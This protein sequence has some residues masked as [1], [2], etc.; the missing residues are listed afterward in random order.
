MRFQY[1]NFRVKT[2]EERSTGHVWT[3]GAKWLGI[4][5]A[6]TIFTVT[7]FFIMPLAV[8]GH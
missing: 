3:D 5:I 7:L 1:Q 4:A 2:V 8:G 6:A